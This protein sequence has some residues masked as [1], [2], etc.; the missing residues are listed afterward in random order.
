MIVKDIVTEI[1]YGAIENA[2]QLGIQVDIAKQDITVEHPQ[3][4]DH[5]DFATN[6]PLQLARHLKRNPFDIAEQLVSMMPK[7][8]AISKVW[9]EAPGFINFTLNDTWLAARIDALLD[10]TDLPGEVNIGN[11]ERLQIEFVSVNPTGP[12]HVGHARGAVLGDA[13]ARILTAAGYDVT[14]EYYVNDAG[15]QMDNFYRSLYAR[16]LQVH[17][18]PAE[19]PE[20]GYIGDYLID[21]AHDISKEKGTMFTSMDPD[22]GVRKIGQIGLEKMLD[23]IREDLKRLNV[24]FD[25]WFREYTLHDGGQVEAAINLMDQ[26]NFMVEKEGAIWFRSTSLG[27]EKDNVLV[28]S[29]GIPTYFAADVAYHYDK[30]IVRYFPRVINIWGADHQGHVGRMKAAV[31]AF[32]VDPDRLVII[33][34]QMVTIKRGDQRLRASKRTGELVTLPQLLDEVGS[35]PC[36]YFFLARSPNSQM[37]FDLDLAKKESSDNPVYYIQYAHA[38]MTSILRMAEEKSLEYINGN[39]LLLKDPS[40]LDLIRKMLTLPEVIESVAVTLEPHNLPHYVQELATSFHWF[41]QQCRVISDQDADRE[42]T[43][44]RLKLVAAARLVLR[45]CLDLMGMESPD[46]M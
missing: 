43:K 32:G 13:L 15:R 38:R 16:Y 14:R 34:S 31:K 20:D 27:E 17:G 18:Q 23:S 37:D 5:G 26:R 44:A 39:V 21:L 4:S 2:K 41:Y 8:D 25:V 35:D 11:G 46:Q 36:R 6:L 28:R 7:S 40:E 12:I 42:I 9:A 29:N 1:L 45:S 3:R 19:M 10:G 22:E 24:E 30:F 33:I